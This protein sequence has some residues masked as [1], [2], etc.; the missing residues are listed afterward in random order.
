MSTPKINTSWPCPPP[1]NEKL[2]L[3]SNPVPYPEY[4]YLSILAFL[5]KVTG[6]NKQFFNAGSL[7]WK[8]DPPNS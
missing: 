3:L 2:P 4:P 1:G 8:L 5:V 6:P 7:I